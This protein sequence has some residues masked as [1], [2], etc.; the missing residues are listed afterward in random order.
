MADFLIILVA[1]SVFLIFAEQITNISK[2]IDVAYKGNVN[3][4]FDKVTK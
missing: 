4:E 2:I 3:E 1:L